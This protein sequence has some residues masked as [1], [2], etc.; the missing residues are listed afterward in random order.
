MKTLIEIYAE[1]RKISEEML[2]D[3]HAGSVDCGEAVVREDFS[4]F[5]G[6]SDV[7]TYEEMLEIEREYEESAGK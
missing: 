3:G 7:I 2:A 1:W 5:A 4:A 6:L